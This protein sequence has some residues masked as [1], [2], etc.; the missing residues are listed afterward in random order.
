MGQT[1]QKHQKL[2]R[3]AADILLIV[4]AVLLAILNVRIARLSQPVEQ[5]VVTQEKVVECTHNWKVIDS[6][7][8]FDTVIV[9][10]DK[11]GDIVMADYRANAF[12]ERKSKK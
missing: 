6:N 8:E 11:C 7:D 5:I 12:I 2:L 3:I 1:G 4:A 10:C 9:S